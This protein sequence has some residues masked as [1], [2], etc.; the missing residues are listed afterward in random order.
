MEM[1]KKDSRRKITAHLNRILA[2]QVRGPGK[3]N[4]RTSAFQI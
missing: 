4:D 1:K 3:Q 2:V